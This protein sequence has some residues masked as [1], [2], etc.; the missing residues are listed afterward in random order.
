[1]KNL[2]VICFVSLLPAYI[3]LA[4]E[5][6]LNS[7]LGFGTQKI[8]ESNVTLLQDAIDLGYRLIDGAKKYDNIDIIIKTIKK[9]QP[10]RLYFIYKI[11][12]PKS[13]DDVLEIKQDVESVIN[14]IGH[15]DALMFHSVE[16]FYDNIDTNFGKEIIDYIK[17]LIDKNLV[18][19]FGLSNVGG[20]YKEIVEA[21]NNR[22]L[23][24]R[25]I[26][27]KF[28]NNILHYFPTAQI[29]S[30][31]KDNSINF[32]AYG[33][34][35]GIAEEGPCH[36]NECNVGQPL[37]HFDD[38]SH[39]QIAA[40][41]KK[42]KVDP[43]M[44]V[45]AFEAKKYGVYQIPTTT[46]LERLK[47]NFIDFTKAYNG[48]QESDLKK[49]SEDIG[50]A[51]PQEFVEVPPT[52]RKIT[53][54]RS[55]LRLI[56]HLISSND[57]L[58]KV[59]NDAPI[60]FD[61]KHSQQILINKLMYLFEQS[62]KFGKKAELKD[63][64]QQLNALVEG[65]DKTRFK[66]ILSN[67]FNLDLN[68]F[69]TPLLNNFISVL[70]KSIP[71]IELLK[72]RSFTF[73]DKSDPKLIYPARKVTVIDLSNDQIVKFDML[74][75]IN[76]DKVRGI[77]QQH[78]IASFLYDLFG[79]SFDLESMDNK[80]DLAAGSTGH[81]SLINSFFASGKHANTKWV[82]IIALYDPFA[83]KELYIKPRNP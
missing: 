14:G 45:I 39:P 2:Y 57:P 78:G 10:E 72:N 30:Y 80:I 63:L 53:N 67:I 28:D 3:A 40:L 24:V 26:E 64:L 31:C 37:I 6:P 12:P 66:P 19:D 54:F 79:D 34:L 36:V 43:M 25:S 76:P 38:L 33:A 82:E 60:I 23:H 49:I 71:R 32:I 18:S 56:K 58:I 11:S 4:G 74:P 81:L 1:M 5:M 17:H 77:L 9:N 59:I 41:S 61:D 35:G 68:Q 73:V 44:L 46:K 29:V 50:L 15:I 16:D 52:L 27:N 75:P 22:G 55:R 62:I 65:D 13:M 47:S 48:L 83:N 7:I 8:N 70:E 69:S 20:R 42:F 21:F 51:L